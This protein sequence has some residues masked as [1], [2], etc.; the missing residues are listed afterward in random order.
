MSEIPTLT[1]RPPAAKALLVFAHGAGAGMRHAFMQDFAEALADRSVATLRF[2]FPYMAEGRHRPDPPAIATAAVREAVRRAQAEAGGLPILAGGKSFGGRM[3]TTAASEATLPVRGLVL[4]G[5]PL[6]TAKRPGI[7]RA[8][9][10][11]AVHLPMLFVQGTRD[12]LADLSLLEPVIAGLGARA[13]LHLEAGADHG[14]HVLKR[15][16]RSDAEVLESVAGVVAEWIDSVLA[17]FNVEQGEV[18]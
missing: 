14:F 15:S 11:S 5:F 18:P 10:L 9:H 4:V 13:R 17:A 3:T 7:E 2:E 8:R 6:H 16:G 1:L 12:T